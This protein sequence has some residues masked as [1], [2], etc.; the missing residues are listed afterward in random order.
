MLDVYACSKVLFF[1]HSSLSLSHS[2]TYT[3]RMVVGDQKGHIKEVDDFNASADFKLLSDTHFDGELWALDV[4]RNDNNR[5]V[6]AGEDNTI[7]LWDAA[8]H[9]L[10]ATQAITDKLGPRRRR[11]RAATTSRHPTNA[12][13]RGIAFSPDGAD[14]AVG[15]NAGLMRVVNTSD[16]SVKADVNLNNFSKTKLD[17]QK[18]REDSSAV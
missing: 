3:Q 5:F 17:V 6:T 18:V 12:C 9:K 14:I 11:T 8:A 16:L 1:I 15:S 13:A 10:V 4:D 2:H 7:R